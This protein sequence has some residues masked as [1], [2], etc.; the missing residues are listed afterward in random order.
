MTGDRDAGGDGEDSDVVRI[1]DALLDFDEELV[2]TYQ[3]RR[4]TGIAYE[5]QPGV[6][7]SEISYVDGRQEGLARDWYPS[8]RLK[9]ETMYVANGRHGHSREFREDGTLASEASYE[10]DIL[11][12]STRF[13]EQGNTVERFDIPEEGPG[14]AHLQ[15][16][17]ENF[18]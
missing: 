4:F 15:R 7:R 8:G 5:D 13:D 1:P 18:G 17:R 6:G 16:L 14:F 10:Y 11:V 3:G 2:Y 12:R 9:G